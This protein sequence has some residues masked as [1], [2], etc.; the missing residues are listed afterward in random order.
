MK[1]DDVIQA[2]T[3][4]TGLARSPEYEAAV[5]STK[6]LG[7]VTYP[8]GYRP[9]SYPLPEDEVGIIG[10]RID[11]GAD[12][13]VA[14]TESADREALSDGAALH[15]VQHPESAEPISEEADISEEA[16]LIEEIELL[17]DAIV[18]EQ[19]RDPP[20]MAYTASDDEYAITA[21]VS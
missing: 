19:G 11:F 14:V 12:D 21:G 2:T 3:L 15:N 20:P 7:P 18:S 16:L 5:A 9:P 8:G 17:S 6:T 4:Y 13:A 1:N 10:E